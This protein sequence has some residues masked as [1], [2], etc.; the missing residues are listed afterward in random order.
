MKARIKQVSKTKSGQYVLTLVSGL[1]NEFNY[2]RSAKQLAQDIKDVSPL[3]YKYLVGTIVELPEGSI[4][5]AGATV[6]N[7]E[8]GEVITLKSRQYRVAEGLSIDK[9]FAHVADWG[10]AMVKAD[11]IAE[12]L[13][14]ESLAEPVFVEENAEAQLV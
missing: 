6:T 9:A 13:H 7:K 5:E 8:T 14:S 11:M 1:K 12:M 2:F 10:T 4:L 3:R